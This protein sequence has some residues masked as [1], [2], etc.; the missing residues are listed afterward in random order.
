MSFDWADDVLDAVEEGLLPT[1]EGDAAKL[2][3]SFEA[4]PRPRKLSDLRVGAQAK[5]GHG[6]CWRGG[7]A[8]H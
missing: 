1:F 4:D 7:F 8:D 3:V 2:E 5:L 6:I